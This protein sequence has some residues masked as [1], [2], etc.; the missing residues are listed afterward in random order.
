MAIIKVNESSLDYATGDDNLKVLAEDAG[1]KCATRWF[2]DP[3]CCYDINDSKLSIENAKYIVSAGGDVEDYQLFIEIES[4]EELV[5]ISLIGSTQKNE[6]DEDVQVTWSQWLAPNCSPTQRAGRLF[7]GTQ[8][9]GIYTQG[10]LPMSL[11]TPVL[12]KLLKIEDL[13]SVPDAELD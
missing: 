2:E 13:P 12:D 11:L 4:L 5:P 6:D 8:C 9:C 10:C 1:R 7:I 3:L